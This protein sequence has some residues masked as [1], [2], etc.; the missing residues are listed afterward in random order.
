MLAKIF[1]VIIPALII[2]TN[3]LAQ[4]NLSGQKVAGG[5]LNEIFTVSIPTRDGGSI[6]A[7]SSNSGISGEKTTDSIGG[8]DYWIVKYK[9]T[10]AIEWTKTLGGSDDDYLTCIQQTSDGGYLAGGYSRSSISG[11]KTENS[12]RRNDY[13]IVKLDSLSNIQWDKTIGGKNQDYLQSLQQTRDGGY[14]LGG[15]SK[16]E[17]SSE[18]AQDSRDSSNDYWLVKLDQTGMIIW[19]K[20]IGGNA[21]DQLNSVRQTKDGGYILG[22]YSES[23][24]SGEKTDS[25][26]GIFDYW[27]VKTDSLG[28]VQW[29]KTMGGV[30]RDLLTSLVLTMDGGYFLS[31]YSFSKISGEKTGGNIGENTTSDYWVVKLDSLHNIEWDKTFGGTLN[32]TCLSAIQTS[33]TGFI[34]AGYSESNIS[35]QKSENS[36]GGLDFWV[37]KLD[38]TGTLLWDKTIGGSGN[39]YLSCV[40]ETSPNNYTLSGYSLSGVSGDKTVPSR[41][42][43]DF[44]TLNLGYTPIAPAGVKAPANVDNTSSKSPEKNYFNVYPNPAKNTLY[45]QTNGRATFSLINRDGKSLVT[46]NINSTGSINVAN[47]SPGLYFIKNNATGLSHQIIIQ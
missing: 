40:T 29:D 22:G 1:Y 42:G 5:S 36:K 47:L 18:K 46:K 28:T 24:I 7:G 45:V 4:F 10:G 3:C 11:N 19:S 41:G 13:W 38:K 30:R 16:S 15:Y 26:R 6:G 14:I 27:L 33:D 37:V 23:K 17:I 32:D 8:F 43:T 25:S 12:R 2:T 44:W 34:L 21:Y 39:D 35:G 9:K 31:G 20:T